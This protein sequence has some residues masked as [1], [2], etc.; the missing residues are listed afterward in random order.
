M[1]Q[2]KP[3]LERYTATPLEVWTAG[4]RGQSIVLDSQPSQPTSATSTGTDFIATLNQELT[5]DPPP[6]AEACV[7]PGLAPAGVELPDDS[8]ASVQAADAANAIGNPRGSTESNPTNDAA[9]KFTNASSRGHQGWSVMV[10]RWIGDF[11][12]KYLGRGVI[13]TNLLEANLPR[14]AVYPT[15]YSDRSGRPLSGRHRYAITFPAGRP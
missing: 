3:I 10:D 11:G 15:S 6:S 5:I 9:T 13:A 12:T 7:L 14:I 4:A 1:E 2:V 8:A